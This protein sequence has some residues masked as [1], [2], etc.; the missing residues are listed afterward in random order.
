[1]QIIYRDNF[2]PFL[3]FMWDYFLPEYLKQNPHEAIQYASILVSAIK[4]FKN[5]A[6]ARVK[7]FE[8]SYVL[9]FIDEKH[10]K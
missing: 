3:L 7:N 4:N 6:I 8:T 5:T 1:M 10:Y 9:L 2:T